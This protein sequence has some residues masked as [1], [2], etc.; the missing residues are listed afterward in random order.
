MSF[1]SLQNEGRCHISKHISYQRTSC[2]KSGAE[3]MSNKREKLGARNSENLFLI[4]TWSVR[5][6]F[7]PTIFI[8]RVAVIGLSAKQR[9]LALRTC[10]QELLFF[11]PGDWVN[12]WRRVADKSC[13]HFFHDEA[14]H[15]MRWKCWHWIVQLKIDWHDIE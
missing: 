2:G 5:I 7:S 13:L 1:K 3:W 9:L 4:T 6:S 12:M 15:R 14:P 8:S 10:P 11:L